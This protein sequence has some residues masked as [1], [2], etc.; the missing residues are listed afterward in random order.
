MHYFC[1]NFSKI[2]WGGGRAPSIDPILYPS[3][4]SISNFWIR[5]CP[6]SPHSTS[7]Y[8]PQQHG[9]IVRAVS[10]WSVSSP[11]PCRVAARAR[12]WGRRVAR[13]A[14]SQSLGRSS[15]SHGLRNGTGRRLRAGEPPQQLVS[16]LLSYR[17]YCRRPSVIRRQRPHLTPATETS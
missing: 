15:A 1:I 12:W 2:F 5:R 11:A 9:T 6:T 3:A 13:H 14:V 7:C 8:S 10:A 4:P 17:Y 16:V